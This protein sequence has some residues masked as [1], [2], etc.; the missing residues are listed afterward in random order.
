MDRIVNFKGIDIVISESPEKE[1]EGQYFMIFELDKYNGAIPYEFSDIVD[2]FA[3]SHGGE[4]S[5]E[6]YYFFSNEDVPGLLEG[7]QNFD[8]AKYDREHEY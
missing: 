8:L 2:E 4:E 7:A 6:S 1:S 5:M 3:T